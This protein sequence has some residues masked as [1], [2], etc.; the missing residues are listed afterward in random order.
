MGL[1]N[2]RTVKVNGKTAVPVW[3][4]RQAGRYHAHYQGMKKDH[5]FMALCKGPELACEVTMGPIRDFKFDAAILFSDLLFPLEQMGLGLK[6][7]PGPKLDTHLDSPEKMKD[8]KVIE[9]A[10]TFYAFQGEACKLLKETLPA[11]KTLLGFVGAPWT[12]YTYAVDGGH[13]GNLINP[14]KGFYDGRWQGFNEVLFENV[15]TEMDIQVAGGADGMC[16]FDTAAGECT[17]EDYRDFIVPQIKRIA[18]EFKRRNPD[19]KLIY[20]SKFTHVEYLRELQEDCIDV[21][22]VDWRFNIADVLKEFSKDYM[23]QGNFDP[24]H[25]HLPWP[26]L[27]EKLLKWWQEISTSGADLSRWICGLG[28]GVLQHTPEENVRN[29]VA[30]I[31]EKF[32]Y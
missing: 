30:L 12:L 21:L 28:H 15:L 2:D 9:D 11:N 27:E 29:A 20:Y 14:K 1:F 25:L 23:I 8:L 24:A 6:Y 4:M 26:I 7:A 13:S 5:D 3:F 17:K 32:E 18:Q 16:L 10:K 19:T 22:G 31:Q